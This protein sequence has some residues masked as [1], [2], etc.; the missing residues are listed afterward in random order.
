M[1]DYTR[2]EVLNAF[3]VLLEDFGW[4]ELKSDLCDY[5]T[6]RYIYS[7]ILR[8]EEVEIK[9]EAAFGGRDQGS[10]AWVVFRVGDQLFRK[11]GYYA[12]HYG[13]DWDG[14]FEEVVATPK[15]ITVYEPKR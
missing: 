11:Q 13:F 5:A 10:E 7:L 15:T 4:G 14:T 3:E 2:A 9:G 8:G 12:S 6:G 1:T